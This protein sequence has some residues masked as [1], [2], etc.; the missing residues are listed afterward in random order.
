MEVELEFENDLAIQVHSINPDS[1]PFNPNHG[2][3]SH[4]LS[5]C[6]L[7]LQLNN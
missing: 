6:K 1:R 3:G 7:L 4:V 2:V 5:F